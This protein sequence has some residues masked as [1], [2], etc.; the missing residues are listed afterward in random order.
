MSAQE[1]WVL[2]LPL[3]VK[4]NL[5]RDA[6]KESDFGTELTLTKIFLNAPL[7]KGGVPTEMI[8][9]IRRTANN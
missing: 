9:E 6:I 4:L 8:E 1:E 7:D 3:E 2:S 5:L